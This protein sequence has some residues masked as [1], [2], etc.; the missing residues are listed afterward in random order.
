MLQFNRAIDRGCGLEICA[1]AGF[2]VD[3]AGAGIVR[4][5]TGDTFY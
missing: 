3:R 4:P 1:S 2:E 5:V